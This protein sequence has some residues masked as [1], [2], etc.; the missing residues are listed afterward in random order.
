M[1]DSLG[2]S[3]CKFAIGVPVYNEAPYI[4]ETLLSIIAT[5]GDF[6]PIL[7]SDNGS[8][9][10]TVE[11]VNRLADK[12]G[13]IKLIVNAGVGVISNFRN[14]IEHANSEYFCWISGHDIMRGTFW[15]DAV[16]F[17]DENPDVAWVYGSCQTIDV[18][19][20]PYDSK[21]PLDSDVDTVGIADEAVM[22]KLLNVVSGMFIH[23]VFRR[24]MM[25]GC[26]Y[27]GGWA[28]DRCVIAYACFRGGV[29]WLKEVSIVRRMQRSHG[30]GETQEAREARYREWGLLEYER[31]GLKPNYYMRLKLFK[32]YIN[33]RMWWRNWN[34]IVECKKIFQLLFAGKFRS[35][36]FRVIR[37][38]REVTEVESGFP[39]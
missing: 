17:L 32:I 23:G 10:G 19:G 14:C 29:R 12:Y 6:V 37:D 34:S 7:V 27:A 28:G 24:K 20:L 1:N 35:S 3:R 15:G 5:V 11:I 13:S 8:A 16:K 9:D 38:L 30:G 39:K 33:E 2:S 22:R 4:E 18:D 25:V 36:L 21:S 31:S 26:P